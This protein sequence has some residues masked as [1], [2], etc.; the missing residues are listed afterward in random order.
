MGLMPRARGI[1]LGAAFGYE[2][3]GRFVDDGYLHIQQCLMLA[4]GRSS[5]FARDQGTVTREYCLYSR[6]LN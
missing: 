6:P 2:V 4:G 3:Y 1:G 5:Q